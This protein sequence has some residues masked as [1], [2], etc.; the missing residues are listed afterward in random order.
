MEMTRKMRYLKFLDLKSLN[1]SLYQVIITR[2][3]EGETVFSTD[4]N[5]NQLNVINI[6]EEHY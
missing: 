3:R 4:P 1:V 5:I 6:A 2:E